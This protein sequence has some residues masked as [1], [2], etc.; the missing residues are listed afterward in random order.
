MSEL[1]GLPYP[2]KGSTDIGFILILNCLNLQRSFC[3]VF[4]SV[5]KSTARLIHHLCCYPIS[6]TRLEFPVRVK[7]HQKRLIR[8]LNPYKSL[9]RDPRTAIDYGQIFVSWIPKSDWVSDFTSG[10]D[11]LGGIP[12]SEFGS[13]STVIR[14]SL[15]TASSK[16]SIAGP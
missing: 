1:T 15:R 7:M 8:S 4:S 3:K 5:S 2:N 10:L 12:A 16:S 6:L 13:N 14:P 11:V 9:I